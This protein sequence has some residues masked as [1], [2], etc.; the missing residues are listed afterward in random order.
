VACDLPAEDAVTAEPAIRDFRGFAPPEP[1]MET[2]KVVD[3][4]STP[5]Q[6]LQ[7]LYDRNPYLLFPELDA[8]ALHYRVTTQDSGILVDIWN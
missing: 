3:S 8:R 5:G 2:L 1:L 6:S 7:A 4:W